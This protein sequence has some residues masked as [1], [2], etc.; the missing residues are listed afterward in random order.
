[1]VYLL[2]IK[3]FVITKYILYFLEVIAS[4]LLSFLISNYFMQPVY[5]L[6]I[7]VAF[8]FVFYLIDVLIFKI[9]IN[10]LIKTEYKFYKVFIK[11]DL[12]ESNLLKMQ[13]DN[14]YTLDIDR[15]NH[16]KLIVFESK[17]DGKVYRKVSTKDDDTLEV[18]CTNVYN[19][20][21][22]DFVRVANNSDFFT[23]KTL[24]YYDQSNKII[25]IPVF[26][27]SQ[28]KLSLISRYQKYYYL[29]DKICG[30]DKV[31]KIK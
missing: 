29:L 28:L 1:M 10:K 5:L 11:K 24:T 15:H 8:I 23:S 25:Y 9:V 17:I 21:T 12:L 3:I 19:E 14:V 20:E 22:F 6:A 30:F 18:I 7:F 31:E 4:A 27:T 16:L 26:K 13:E 2:K